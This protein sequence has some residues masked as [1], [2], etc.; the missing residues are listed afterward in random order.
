MADDADADDYEQQQCH[1]EC[2]GDG[3]CAPNKHYWQT[4]QAEAFGK[5]AG[6]KFHAFLREAFS[7]W[8]DNT[9]LTI[10]QQTPDTVLIF[11]L[12]KGNKNG[13]YG[14]NEMVTMP[15]YIET[16]LG[17]PPTPKGT[18]AP[19]G[20]DYI[21][22]LESGGPDE[23]V[24]LDQAAQLFKTNRCFLDVKGEVSVDSVR[25]C[26]AKQIVLAKEYS[27]LLEE[28]REEEVDEYKRPEYLQIKA[29]RVEIEMI[30]TKLEEDKKKIYK[31]MEKEIVHLKDQNTEQLAALN[32]EADAAQAE[33]Q[34]ILDA[35]QAEFDKEKA[36]MTKGMEKL[37][38]EQ[39]Y[40][41]AAKAKTQIEAA[42]A[43]HKSKMR[44]KEEELKLKIKPITDKVD[45]AVADLEKEVDAEK[46]TAEEKIERLK[47]NAGIPQKLE[48]AAALTR[49][50]QS[51][52]KREYC[53]VVAKS[54]ATRLQVAC[55]LT[56]RMFR[57]FDE[58]EIII[59]V[60]AD[61]L[62]LMREAD[63]TDYRVQ[64]EAK[65]FRRDQSKRGAFQQ[66]YVKAF[67]NSSELKQ[68]G[69]GSDGV[70]YA[71]G[72]EALDACQKMLA[73]NAREDDPMIDE[74]KPS[75]LCVDPALWGPKSQRCHQKLESVLKKYRHNENASPGAH[76][77]YLGGYTPFKFDWKLLPLYRHYDI[78]KEQ[79]DPGSSVF[80]QVDR[81]RLV[82]SIVARHLNLPSMKHKKM[83]KDQF[84][85]HDQN[86]LDLLNDTWTNKLSF[87]ST[88]DQPLGRIR[89]YFGEKVAM[90]FAWLQFYTNCLIPIALL[91]IIV[92]VIK[93][94]PFLEK[95][96]ICSPGDST[97]I[98][99][100]GPGILLAAFGG[101]VAVWSTLFTEFWRRRNGFLNVWWGQVGCLRQ[102]RERPEFVG[103]YLKD[104]RTD[105]KR[106]Q[107]SSSDRYMK[108]IWIGIFIVFLCVAV[109][110]GAIG[111]I[112]FWKYQISSQYLYTHSDAEV[113]GTIVTTTFYEVN[114]GY[115]QVAG[116][117]LPIDGLGTVLVGVAN[118]LQIGVLNE[119]YKMIAHM[120][121]NWENHRTYSEYEQH[122]TTKTFLFQFIN[123][124][125]S[126]FYIAFLKR[127]TETGVPPVDSI[128]RNY[129]TTNGNVT[130]DYIIEYFTSN[131]THFISLDDG[132]DGYTP[133][134][135]KSGYNDIASLHHLG[136][137]P[138][139]ISIDETI[140]PLTFHINATNSTL[141]EDLLWQPWTKRDIDKRLNNGCLDGN[142]L[143]ELQTQ[144]IAVF[145][146]ALLVNN[147]MEVLFPAL[148]YEMSM[149]I[150]TTNAKRQRNGKSTRGF[151][152]SVLVYIFTC[153]CCT[154]PEEDYNYEADT[155]GK[156]DDQCGRECAG[157][158]KGSNPNDLSK[159]EGVH[160]V[161]TQ[162]VVY[163]EA[164]RQAKLKEYNETRT[165]EDYAEMLIQYGFVTLFVVAFPL[166]PLLAFIN[167]LAEVHI[168][169]M[170]LT[171]RVGGYRRPFPRHAENIGTW[172]T[173]MTITTQ[174][175][176]FTNCVLVIFVADLEFLPEENFGRFLLFLAAEHGLIAIKLTFDYLVPN[177]PFELMQLND[178]N[179][180]INEKVIHDMHN[181]DDDCL[182]VEAAETDPE[183]EIHVPTAKML[184]S[185]KGYHSSSHA[186]NF[187]YDDDKDDV[188]IPSDSD[189]EDPAE[190]SAETSAA[191]EAAPSTEASEED[192]DGK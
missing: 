172:A 80:R 136:E 93:D 34:K 121:T 127:W 122:L 45:A 18:I 107:H 115:N 82:D 132:I 16:M 146:S 39:N 26:K 190:A 129:I 151:L 61:T 165:F 21:A 161:D 173:I 57:S 7:T 8:T 48:Q 47:A 71:T 69:A 118:A 112:F 180:F 174:I 187:T 85:L 162:I 181:E 99:D 186:D 49:A 116:Y 92:F 125:S 11:P 30:E 104:S 101:I 31:H 179:E 41:D 19:A 76:R 65:P 111:G 88:L 147:M 100:E 2:H 152:L 68:P 17:L 143:A 134:T 55:G 35:L 81:I 89:D 109:V 53:C 154:N 94:T 14:P 123:S 59:T 95:A 62:D 44:K 86:D 51:S 160:L 87:K 28:V 166:T 176:V 142:C 189:D 83:L 96:E 138:H 149:W 145:V 133:E 1:D 74:R 91:G 184:E 167:N 5:V 23:D 84:S 102:E 157:K 106:L 70:A 114:P 158:A 163:T 27:Q 148:E 72:A 98:C 110:I 105:Q 73:E 46:N 103:V 75:E 182:W 124:Y 32:R 60:T 137:R 135:H 10:R 113:N 171:R 192:K 67:S 183:R 169:A 79:D 140:M 64:C 40:T 43:K 38:A 50:L 131:A 13:K 12:V 144:L 141:E 139:G 185:G 188:S 164:E 119:A 22:D 126:F 15:K 52:T 77:V 175:S 108:K 56:T 9:N 78:S 58:D 130:R 33:N 128:L 20:D 155:A 191:D 97:F 54:V 37:G 156:C 120:L 25:T 42:E 117:K 3:E 29:I 168:D 90:Y 66:Q 36:E 170:K 6:R 24:K 178:R 150:E 153:G 4:N 177:T 63:R 159:A